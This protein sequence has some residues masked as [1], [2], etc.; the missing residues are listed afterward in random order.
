MD[1]KERDFMN[2]KTV[3]IIVCSVLLIAF[4]LIIVGVNDGFSG[5]PSKVEK[6]VRDSIDN[7]YYKH[8]GFV[9]DY[10]M[11]TIDD[12]DCDI[13]DKD[14][15]GRYLLECNIHYWPY[16]PDGYVK[17]GLK[18]ES[19]YAIYLEVEDENEGTE[20][21]IIFNKLNTPGFKLSSCWEESALKQLGCSSR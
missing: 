11:E 6:R 20:D 14:G 19:F 21:L 16:V 4:I 17:E 8:G 7:A 1:V 3:I 15:K 9:T 12:L 18:Y 13:I 10:I 5:I 2:K